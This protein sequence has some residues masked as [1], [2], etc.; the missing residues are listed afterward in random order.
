MAKSRKTKTRATKKSRKKPVARAKASP[1]KARQPTKT[2]TTP[3]RASVAKAPQA[4]D[5]MAHAALSPAGIDPKN[6][7]INA[8]VNSL[9]DAARPGWTDNG[10]MGTDY[11]YDANSMPA[12]LSTVRACLKTKGYVLNMNDP[13]FIA[14]CATAAVY[15]LKLLVYGKTTP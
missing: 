10:N 6:A 8:C 2:K 1:K 5:V 12:F 13:A 11:N 7:A 15:R 3:K 14:S 9:M 4:P